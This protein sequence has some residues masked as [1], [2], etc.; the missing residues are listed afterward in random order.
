MLACSSERRLRTGAGAPVCDLSRSWCV[1]CIRA[2]PPCSPL[3]C[4]TGVE[5]R[6]ERLGT[7]AGM[8]WTHATFAGPGGFDQLSGLLDEKGK[9]GW[10]GPAHSGFVTLAKTYGS[11]AVDSAALLAVAE[12]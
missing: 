1:S 6:A 2:P 8:P 7:R 4:W 10:R 3:G 11:S 12:G 9:I 5:R